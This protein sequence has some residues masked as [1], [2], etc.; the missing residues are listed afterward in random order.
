MSGGGGNGRLNVKSE[1]VNAL[2]VEDVHILVKEVEVQV[3]KFVERVVEVPVYVN[4]ENAVTNV[5]DNQETVTTKY[6][7]F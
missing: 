4:K 5:T 2:V 3:P 6:V 1:K 7:I